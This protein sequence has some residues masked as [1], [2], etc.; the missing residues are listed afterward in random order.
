MVILAQFLQ[1]SSGK[2][3]QEKKLKVSEICCWGLVATKGLLALSYRSSFGGWLG[4]F[5]D[6]RQQVACGS[7]SQKLSPHLDTL[8]VYI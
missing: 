8:S 6:W 7:S 3:D 4:H 5:T 2:Q 1:R